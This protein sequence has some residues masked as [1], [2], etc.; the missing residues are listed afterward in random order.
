[1]RNNVTMGVGGIDLDLGNDL[2]CEECKGQILLKES[3]SAAY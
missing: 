2:Q 1:M 3:V